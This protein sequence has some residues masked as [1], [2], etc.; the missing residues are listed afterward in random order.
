MKKRRTSMLLS[1]PLASKIRLYYLLLL[2]PVVLLL[3]YSLYNLWISN[4]QYEDMINSVVV[5]SEFSLDFQED[6]DY[7]MGMFRLWLCS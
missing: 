2:I 4:R 3:L 6:F 5:A 1:F 7:E